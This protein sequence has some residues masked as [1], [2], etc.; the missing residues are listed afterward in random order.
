MRM[1]VSG[2]LGSTW[3]AEM[4]S[5]RKAPQTMAEVLGLS[6]TSG[7]G[8]RASARYRASRDATTAYCDVIPSASEGSRVGIR[9]GLAQGLKA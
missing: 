2:D 8:P 5:P 9:S 6:L 4:M 1:R 3:N 7:P